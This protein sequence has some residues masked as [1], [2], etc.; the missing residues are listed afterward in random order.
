MIQTTGKFFRFQDVEPTTTHAVKA[1]GSGFLRAIQTASKGMRYSKNMAKVP[2]PTEGGGMFNIVKD[3][4]WT[5]SSLD[6]VTVNNTPTITLREMEV[7]NPAFFNNLALLIDQLVTP[8]K[9]GLLNIGEQIF[10]PAASQN[11]SQQALGPA[12]AGGRGF[13][14]TIGAGL[15]G[16]TGLDELFSQKNIHAL[17]GSGVAGANAVRSDLEAMRHLILGANTITGP[18]YLRQYEKLYGIHYTGFKYKV[19]YLQDGYKVIDNSWGGDQGKGFLL[20][21]AQSLTK[22]TSIAAPSVGVDFAKTFDYP[23]NGP[24]YDINFFLDN[25]VYNNESRALDNLTFIYL[26]LY[27]NLPNRINRTS[28]APPVIYQA[29]LPGVFSYRWSFLSKLTVNFIGV[30]RPFHANIGGE[31]TEAI[32]PE[33]YEVQLTL[34]SLTPETKNLFYDSLN[35]AVHSFEEY[36]EPDTSYENN[37][38][39]PLPTREKLSPLQEM[40][41]TPS[42]LTVETKPVPSVPKP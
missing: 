29:S 15:A 1:S 8:E 24:S 20:N 7:V 18:A 28:L 31:Q 38:T 2:I 16:L 12:P 14:T 13:W 10:D 25:T 11:A 40:Q 19:P 34:T 39:R 30:R 4:R 23:Q 6:S 3:F 17:F 41:R 35:P 9:A 21:T 33:G 27:Q 26:L 32:I 36:K 22:L 5:K 37:E 42:G